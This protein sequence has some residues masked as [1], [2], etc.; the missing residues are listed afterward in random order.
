MGYGPVRLLSP[1]QVGVPGV[2][3]DYLLPALDDLIA[4]YSAAADAGEAVL[5]AII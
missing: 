3:D 4:F 1:R 2:L 5:L